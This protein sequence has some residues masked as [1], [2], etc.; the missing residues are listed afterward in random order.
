M[1]IEDALSGIGC[2]VEP[3]P[4]KGK[5]ATYVTYHLVLESG[6]TYGDSEEIS[7]DRLIAVDLFTASAWESKASAI[8]AALV[9]AGYTVLSMGPHI[10]ETDE[11]LNHIPFT[12]E[13]ET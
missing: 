9:A 4:Y 12:V 6:G 13:E 8:K 5:A 10:E 2:P 11:Q 7:G 1:S 3:V